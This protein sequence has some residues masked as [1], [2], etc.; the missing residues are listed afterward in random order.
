[1]AT[2]VTLPPLDFTF[3]IGPASGSGTLDSGA[4]GSPTTDQP[5]SATPKSVP[6]AKVQLLNDRGDRDAEATWLRAATRPGVVEL[7]ST[8][9]APF[10][11]VTAHAG[12]RTM[13]TA[14]L[15][16]ADGLSALLG[17]TEL[18]IGLHQDGFVHG[19]LTVDHVIIGQTGPVLCSPDGTITDPDVDLE[20]V[21]RCM[22]ELGRQWD[23]R[24]ASSPWRAQWDALVQRLEDG[25]DPSRSAI[26]TTEAL[27]RLQDK[28]GPS[29]PDPQ[30]QTRR[31]SRGLVAAAFAVAIAIAG[32]ALV[33]TNEP[34][35]A[36]GPHVVIE[37]STYAI[38]DSGDDVAHLA[39]PCDA[40]APVVMLRPSTGE[41]WAFSSVGDGEA[42]IAVAV[43]PGAT[44]LRRERRADR[45]C[46]V[47]VARGPAGSTEIDTATLAAAT[48]RS[49]TIRD[50]ATTNAT[51]TAQSP[52]VSED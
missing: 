20:G 19:K 42:G 22:R 12:A 3:G 18:L 39:A 50:A 52:A 10:T 28:P 32:L 13:R 2:R 31:A 24:G 43:V 6:V 30:H 23:E 29:A 46:E 45:E 17:V 40:A 47:A 16:P 34:A 37:G 27:R 4:G 11:I 15:Q 36:T 5:V 25:T 14:R 9:L 8:S 26:R 41:V 33:P 38:G 7:L 49:A 35:M 1:M 48:T 51:P 21:A 44:D